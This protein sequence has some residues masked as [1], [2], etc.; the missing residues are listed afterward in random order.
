MRETKVSSTIQ[1][2]S[3]AHWERFLCPF[4][5]ARD[6]ASNG[7]SKATIEETER[8]KKRELVVRKRERRDSINSTEKEE[9]RS[10]QVFMEN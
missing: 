7:I 8:E 6:R 1:V 2:S 3:L 5:S 10:K 4:V 9:A